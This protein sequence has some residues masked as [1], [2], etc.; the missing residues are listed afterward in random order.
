M[1]DKELRRIKRRAMNKDPRWEK[2]RELQKKN[3]WSEANNA[4]AKLE[5]EYGLSMP[6]NRKIIAPPPI[7]KKKTFAEDM[8]ARAKRQVKKKE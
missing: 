4:V 2:V 8:T 7:I 6:G 3:K 5:H 1:K